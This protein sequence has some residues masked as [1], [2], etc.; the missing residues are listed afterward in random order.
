MTLPGG[1]YKQI[2]F[3]VVLYG[4]EGTMVVHDNDWEVHH[5]DEV[6]KHSGTLGMPEH[7]ANFI[8]CMRSRRKPNADVETGYLAT[9]L[10]HLGNIAHRLRRSVK[11]D[12]KTQRFPNDAEADAYLGRTWR[13]PFVVPE[14]V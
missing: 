7:V 2:S 6:K 3:G 1:A 13:P 4:S 5:G 11:F 14:K 12:A 8:D 9:A 10:C